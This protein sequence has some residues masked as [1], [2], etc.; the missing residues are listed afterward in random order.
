[1]SNYPPGMGGREIDEM[2]G[3]CPD[4]APEECTCDEDYGP[5]P[6]AERGLEQDRDF[7]R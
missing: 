2:E 5:D 4:C 6:D 7:W 3:A 1:M